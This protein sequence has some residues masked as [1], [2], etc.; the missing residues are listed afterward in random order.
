MPKTILLIEDDPDNL[1]MLTY[2]LEEEGYHVIAANDCSQ[3]GDVLKFEPELI[4]MDNWLPTISGTEACRKLKEDALTR[5]IPVILVS[6]DHR[7]A[8]L[9]NGSMADGYINKPFDLEE[10][11]AVIRSHI[12]E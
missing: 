5:H 7:L 4:L 3:L 1:E 11:V 9:A 2:I 10:L 8:E 12:G 6:A